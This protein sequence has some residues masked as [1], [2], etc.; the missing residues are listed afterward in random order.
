MIAAILR[1]RAAGFLCRYRLWLLGIV[2][3][4]CFAD[5]AAI[6]I[7]Y[8]V[9]PGYLDH[10]E[11]VVAMISWRV[12]E[13]FPAYP[14]FD[15]PDQTTNIYGPVTYL[16][17]ALPYLLAGPG[18]A[19]GKAA[20]LAAMASILFIVFGTHRRLGLSQ[21]LVATV[22]AAGFVLVAVP[23]SVWNRPD[24]FL[25][26]LVAVSVCLMRTSAPGRPEWGRSLAIALC[27][28][29]A[30]GFKIH[31]G[32]YFVPVA[33][34][35]CTGRGFKIFLFM[36]AVGA[37]AILA[38]FAAEQFS[39]SNYLAWFPLQLGKTADPALLKKVFRY[40][41]FYAAPV[42]FFVAALKWAK[43]AIDWPEKVY[44]GSFVF[45]LALLVVPASKPGAG[46]H[47][48][49][50]LLAICVDMVVRYAGA[51]TG[52][53]MIVQAAVAALA[54]ALFIVS[55]PIQKRFARALHWQEARRITAD[56][57]AVMEAFPDKTI[58]MGT[59][60]TFAGYNRTLYK[61]LL[62]FAGHPYTLDVGV[63]IETSAIGV[64][65]PEGTIT[66]IKDCHTQI[67]LVP[68]GEAPF[69]MT[70]YYRNP[71]FDERFRAAFR[72]NYE[73]RKEFRYFDAWACQ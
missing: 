67:W 55:M 44:F 10:G 43:G 16:V 45:C 32:L 47:H 60:E 15:G 70:G 29:L 57:H 69:A 58:Q 4:L 22:L 34:Y 51:L 35:H 20:G 38:P 19:S 5:V 18:V 53:K 54:A 30:V 25:A 28:G 59:G 12:L 73:K 6:A 8:L 41:I 49:F 14:P 63:I 52:G 65:L 66:R 21:A 40:S 9:Y 72:A 50:P 11:P 7:S 62:A 39:L 33:L 24:P 61:P 37:A 31:A 27:G 68:A 1:S 17:H 71:V 64:P 13:G 46:W 26:L 48:F 56:L 2:A 42:L 36:S 3:V 23:T